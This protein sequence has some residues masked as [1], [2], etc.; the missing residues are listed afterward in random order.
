M[1][2][3]LS[4][5]TTMSLFAAYTDMRKRPLAIVIT[6]SDVNL[7]GGVTLPS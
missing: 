3:L 6:D 7:A 5:T 1:K 4:H 2:L